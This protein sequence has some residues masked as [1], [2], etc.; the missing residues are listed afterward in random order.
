MRE[1]KALS[2]VFPTQVI[3]ATSA[4][5]KRKAVDVGYGLLQYL[6]QTRGFA[7]MKLEMQSNGNSHSMQNQP[8]H[9]VLPPL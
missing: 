1:I 5:D 3:P 6:G 8:G 9:P 4:R 2:I 7:G